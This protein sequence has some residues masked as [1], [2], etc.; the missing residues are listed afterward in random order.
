MGK[1]REKRLLEEIKSLREENRFL[2]KRVE[3]LGRHLL[4]YENAHTPPSRQPKDDTEDG[5]K[6]TPGRK[7]G[8]KGVTRPAILSGV[9]P[10]GGGG[11]K[12]SGRPF[13]R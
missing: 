9:G 12:R 1:G 3:E 4:M 2:R 13:R 8:H 7:A 11:T 6:G 10:E 5:P